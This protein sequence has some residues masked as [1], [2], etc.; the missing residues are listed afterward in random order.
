[1]Y[2]VEEILDR[3]SVKLVK[4]K[5]KGRLSRLCRKIWVSHQVEGME[6]CRFDMG[7]W[8]KS[9]QCQG[10]ASEIQCYKTLWSS[11]VIFWWD[12]IGRHVEWEKW[13]KEKRRWKNEWIRKRMD[14][15]RLWSRRILRQGKCSFPKTKAS[16]NNEKVTELLIFRKF[17]RKGKKKVPEEI[18]ENEGT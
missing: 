14:P 7:A 10:N 3:R 4:G 8:G 5:K 16:K 6:S 11:G 1:M 18:L 2:S 9:Y 15:R 17:I 12:W 13:S